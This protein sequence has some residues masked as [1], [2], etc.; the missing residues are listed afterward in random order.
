MAEREAQAR[1]EAVLRVVL[2]HLNAL[3]ND[4]AAAFAQSSTAAAFAAVYRVGEAHEAALPAPLRDALR[5]CAAR[6]AAAGAV[7]RLAVLSRAARQLAAATLAPPARAVRAAKAAAL[8]DV[9]TAALDANVLDRRDDF[10]TAIQQLCAIEAKPPELHFAPHTEGDEVDAW[11]ALAAA[12]AAPDVAVHEPGAAQLLAFAGE[13]RAALMP[14][15]PLVDEA[16]R[17]LVDVWRFADILTG[18]DFRTT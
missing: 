1:G 2:T 12:A 13:A 4:D 10:I 11:R 16:L 9:A 5:A 14:G 17:H 6:G 8:R 7:A 18:G 15:A 3:A